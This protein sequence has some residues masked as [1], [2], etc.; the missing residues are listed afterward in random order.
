MSMTYRELFNQI[1]HYGDFD[2]MPVLHWTG[3]EETLERWYA[4]GLPRDVNQH[5]FF[6][7][8][9][10]WGGI[11]TNLSLF[12]AFEEEVLE[13]TEEYRIF[14]GSDGVVCQDWK[15]K[16]CIP[17]YIDF[18]LKDARGWDDY[19]QRL[20]PDPARIPAISRAVWLTWQLPAC[21]S[22]LK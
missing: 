5:T 7:T 11:W 14:R 21:Q 17:H 22:S 4:E 18:T 1:M 15:H 20:Q 6:N 12:P 8:Q 16:S 19:K 3:W 2:R 13:E 10:F 9:P